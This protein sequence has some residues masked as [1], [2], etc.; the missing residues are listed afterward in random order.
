MVEHVEAVPGGG[1]GEHLPCCS[2]CSKRSDEVLCLVA[3]E[4]GVHI[5]TSA[6]T[7]APIII[8]KQRGAVG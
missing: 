7:C 2:F 3:G 6:S 5:W 8:A 1:S 4:H